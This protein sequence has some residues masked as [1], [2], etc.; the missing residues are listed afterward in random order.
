MEM[1]SRVLVMLG[2]S[3]LVLCGNPSV[4]PFWIEGKVYCDTCQCG[5]ETPASTY[6]PGARVRVECKDWDTSR[7][8]FSQDAVTDG[9]GRWNMK[10][11]QDHGDEQCSA[12]LLTSSS[13]DCATADPARSR[14]SLV[15]TR[16][17]GVTSNRNAANAMGFVRDQ[18]LPE[19][20][21][22][23]AMYP[24]LDSD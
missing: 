20:E 18:R 3:T 22:V 19:C 4:D 2:L 8:T 6:I 17:N 23:L 7:I 1:A 15:L 9:S 21:A 11:E 24:P 12:I 14:A 13:P 16:D 5:F 10:V